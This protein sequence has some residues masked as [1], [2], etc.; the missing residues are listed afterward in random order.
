VSGRHRRLAQGAC[1]WLEVLIHVFPQENIVA[2][3]ILRRV[4][5]QTKGL[6]QG[7]LDLFRKPELEYVELHLTDHCNLNCKGCGH[8]CPVA[9]PQYADLSRYQSDLHRLRRLFRNIREI[10]LLGGEPLLHPDPAS[11]VTATHAVFPRARVRVVTNGILLPQAAQDFWDACRNTGTGIDLTVYPPLHHRVAV[12]RSLCE[13]KGV[14]LHASDPVSTFDAC[15]NLRGDSD[16]QLAFD[17]CRRMYVNPFLQ[18]GRLYVCSSPAL[19]WHFNKQFDL[20][21]PADAGIDIHAPAVT[22]RAILR[23][24]NR[25]IETCKWCSQDGVSFPW[26]TSKRQLHEWD[27]GVHGTAKE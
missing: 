16:A 12:L 20:R 4:A 23:Q 17:R 1:D 25:P 10:R 14:H 15:L 2:N 9:T 7:A 24:L 26:T 13:A 27:A 5:R 18:A 3:Q 6:V 21:I 11:F 8:F 22:G 19:V